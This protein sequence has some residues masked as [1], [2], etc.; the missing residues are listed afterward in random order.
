MKVKQA[1]AKQAKQA[2]NTII[3]FGLE[4]VRDHPYITMLA[5]FSATIGYGLMK[6]AAILPH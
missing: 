1:N 2:M 4:L 6:L 3:Q 5:G